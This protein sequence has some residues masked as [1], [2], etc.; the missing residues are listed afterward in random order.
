MNP[1]RM[2]DILAIALLMLITAWAVVGTVAA[3]VLGIVWL[4]ALVSP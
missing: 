2:L 3:V 4:S 1:N